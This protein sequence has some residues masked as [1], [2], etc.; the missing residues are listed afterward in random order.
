MFPPVHAALVF[1]VI[2]VLMSLASFTRTSMA[3]LRLFAMASNVFFIG[4]GFFE[5]AWAVFML[6]ACLLPLNTKRYLEI[7]KLTADIKKAAGYTDVTQWLLPHM[8]RRTC[9]AGEVLFRAGDP[10]D[11]M[12]YVEAGELK[13]EG[14]E[15]TLGPGELI[16]EIGLFSPAKRRTQTIVCVTDCELYSITGEMMYHLYFQHP[17]LG[18]YFMRLVVG[19]LQQDIAKERAAQATA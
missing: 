8:A 3:P 6:H 15:H 2:G 14:V 11:S 17:S 13:L 9:K 7:R 4:Y 1:E 19:R 12:I 16:G 10:A 18:F 5:P